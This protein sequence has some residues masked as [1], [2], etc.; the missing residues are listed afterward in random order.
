MVIVSEFIQSNLNTHF[1]KNKE[2][3]E[4]DFPRIVYIKKKSKQFIT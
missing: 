3:L 2:N 1:Y 4:C